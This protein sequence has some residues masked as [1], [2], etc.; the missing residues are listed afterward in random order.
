LALG[1]PR[2]S[3]VNLFVRDGLT[4]CGGGAVVGV[5]LAVLL[6]RTLRTVLYETAPNDPLTF[7]TAVAVLGVA[8]T[9][10][11]VIPARRAASVDPSLTLRQ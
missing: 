4:M 3:V 7:V 2:S 11:C 5:V 9:L 1:A 10:A 6:T 8:A